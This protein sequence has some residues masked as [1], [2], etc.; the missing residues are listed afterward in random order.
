M[1][2]LR[3]HPCGNYRENYKEELTIFETDFGRLW[4]GIGLLSLF[5]ILP[6][7]VKPYMIYV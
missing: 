7:V 6:W 4:F 3:F 2:K 5:L 1:K